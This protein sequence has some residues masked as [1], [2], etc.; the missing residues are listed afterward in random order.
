MHQPCPLVH[1]PMSCKQQKYPCKIV[2]VMV[3]A[4]VNKRHPQVDLVVPVLH[5]V[6]RL[7]SPR[8]PLLPLDLVLLLQ[9]LAPLHLVKQQ[10]QTTMPWE[11]QRGCKVPYQRP[12]CHR[13]LTTSSKTRQ[14]N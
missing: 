9:P 13:L 5:L 3:V 10:P 8:Q 14:P 4:L 1:P 11:T 6:N 12:P 2:V 7:D